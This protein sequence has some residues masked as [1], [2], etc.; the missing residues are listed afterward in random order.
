MYLKQREFLTN[1]ASALQQFVQQI[2]FPQQS[3]T[4]FTQP[5]QYDEYEFQ[6]CYLTLKPN[7]QQ[8]ISEGYGT[9]IISA[10]RA[11]VVNLPRLNRQEASL[12]QYFGI[13]RALT[14]HPSQDSKIQSILRP[15]EKIKRPHEQQIKQLK[16]LFMMAMK[17]AGLPDS[18]PILVFSSSPYGETQTSVAGFCAG[19]HFAGIVNGGNV[20][21]SVG[22]G[23]I[24]QLISSDQKIY[25]QN[26]QEVYESL[27]QIKDQ[28]SNENTGIICVPLISR[29]YEATSRDLYAKNMSDIETRV[30]GDDESMTSNFDQGTGTLIQLLQHIKQKRYKVKTNQLQ[31]LDDDDQ[32]NIYLNSAQHIEKQSMNQYV[33]HLLSRYIRTFPSLLYGPIAVSSAQITCDIPGCWLIFNHLPKIAKQRGT[34]VESIAFH[35]AAN[36]NIPERELTQIQKLLQLEYLQIQPE[37]LPPTSVANNFFNQKTIDVTQLFKIQQK[38]KQFNFLQPG[39][40]SSTT[41]NTILFS[42]HFGTAAFSSFTDSCIDINE[43]MVWAFNAVHDLSQQTGGFSGKYDIFL[44]LA[45]YS[46]LEGR[47]GSPKELLTELTGYVLGDLQSFKL[48][49]DIEELRINY[50]QDMMTYKSS[51]NLRE[52]ALYK[53]LNYK[54][55]RFCPYGCILCRLGDACSG[56][57]HSDALQLCSDMFGQLK[58]FQ[59][60]QFGEIAVAD[61]F[62][63]WRNCLL[64]QKLV[65]MRQAIQAQASF[66][67]Y[68]PSTYDQV[69]VIYQAYNQQLSFKPFFESRVYLAIVYYMIQFQKQVKLT[70]STFLEQFFQYILQQNVGRNEFIPF[71]YQISYNDKEYQIDFGK[72]NNLFYP[73]D[74]A[75]IIPFCVCIYQRLINDKFLKDIDELEIKITK[76]ISDNLE[77][78]IQNCHQFILQGINP[79]YILFL[80]NTAKLINN[81]ADAQLLEF[82]YTNKIESYFKSD[83]ADQVIENLPELPLVISPQ[84]EFDCLYKDNVISTQNGVNYIQAESMLMITRKRETYLS[85]ILVCKQK[86]DITFEQAKSICTGMSLLSGED[87]EQMFKKLEQDLTPTAWELVLN[88]ISPGYV[89]NLPHRFYAQFLGFKLEREVFYPNFQNLVACGVVETIPFRGFEQ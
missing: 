28:K 67:P 35:C 54:K 70:S 43:A 66:K 33:T 8:N 71:T 20:K 62:D 1:L 23:N 80:A 76:I 86:L 57:S 52:K 30:A 14:L 77:K 4:R 83:S 10:E 17:R 81:Y 12:L 87:R 21:T 46:K 37:Q 44:Q 27:G 5:I 39:Y 89:N 13:E 42:C 47:W 73:Y 60:Q 7:T 15:T 49:Q 41:L 78:T 26:Y 59:A 88:S 82:L 11:S 3:W 85:N 9:S 34:A 64:Y 74:N 50:L 18:I 38:Y 72:M 56:L 2:L 55:S 6:L 25:V 32:S 69:M 36:I 16:T 31:Y 79:K 65:S 53:I 51:G 75:F 40:P 19:H 68:L 84:T 58:Q 24:Q 63:A 48:N 22:I 61:T 45:K 29:Y